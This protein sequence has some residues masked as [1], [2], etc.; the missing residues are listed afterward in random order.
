MGIT[1]ACTVGSQCLGNSRADE[2]GEG[3]TAGQVFLTR[4]AVDSGA[5]WWVAIGPTMAL[6]CVA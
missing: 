4:Y 3:S 2:D 6:P 1:A 5:V